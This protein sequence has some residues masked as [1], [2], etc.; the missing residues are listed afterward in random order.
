MFL[1]LLSLFKYTIAYEESSQVIWE[2][3]ISFAYTIV[4]IA[5][6]YLRHPL[7]RFAVPLS[8]W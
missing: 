8:R 3:M 4:R 7:H 5:T 1:S 2:L 6:T